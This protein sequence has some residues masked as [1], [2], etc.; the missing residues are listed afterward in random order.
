M[1][2]IKPWKFTSDRAGSNKRGRVIRS[3][4]DL[5]ESMK[6]EAVLNKLSSCT[7]YCFQC[8]DCF[9]IG[10]CTASRNSCFEIDSNLLRCSSEKRRAA[11]QGLTWRIMC[12]QDEKLWSNK[13]QRL[14]DF[15]VSAYFRL[16]EMTICESEN[17]QCEELQPVWYIHFLDLVDLLWFLKCNLDYSSRLRVASYDLPVVVIIRSPTTSLFMQ[18]QLGERIERLISTG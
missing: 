4:P 12:I 13:N 1:K 2:L 15:L 9:L 14:A 8:F 18:T 5:I 3:F 10:F 6:F 17:W 11:P 7:H 16:W